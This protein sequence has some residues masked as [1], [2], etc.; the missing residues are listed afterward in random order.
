MAVAMAAILVMHIAARADENTVPSASEIVEQ[1]TTQSDSQEVP[2]PKPEKAEQKKTELPAELLKL[3]QS[4]TALNPEK[5][6]MLDL[7]GGRLIVKTEVA[8]RNCILEMLC[9]PEGIKEHE[10]ILRV[11]TKAYVIHTGLVAL[12]AEPGRPARFSPQFEPPSGT[13]LSIYAAWVDEDGKLQR[14]DV[15]D[16]VR[17]NIH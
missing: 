7:K 9:V 3:T 1:T 5:T 14:K 6:V 16:W 2:A 8:C 15:R 12:G 11:K 17:H 10:T 4:A 13:K